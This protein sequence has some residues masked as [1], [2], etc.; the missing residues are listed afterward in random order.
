MVI[1]RSPLLVMAPLIAVGGVIAVV[2][3][4]LGF[5]AKAGWLSINQQA[6][7][8]LTVPLFGAGTDYTIFLASRYRE[9]LR[10][11]PDAHLRCGPR[12]AASA[13]RSPPARGR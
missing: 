11:D 4:L 3:P 1:Y 8:I 10:R 7:S 13:R 12:R 5:V 9:E 2:N 6:T